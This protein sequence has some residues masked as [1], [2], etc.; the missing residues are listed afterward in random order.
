MAVNRRLP[1]ARDS[2]IYS[3]PDKDNVLEKLGL[4]TLREEKSSFV[5]VM[6]IYPEYVKL[7]CTNHGAFASHSSP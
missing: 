6:T 7:G 4:G 1:G 5:V 3:L 2:L